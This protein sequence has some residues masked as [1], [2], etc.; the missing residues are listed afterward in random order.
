M[1]SQTADM[2]SSRCI[3]VPPLHLSAC[4][5]PNSAI[6]L[7]HT[8]SEGTGNGPRPQHRRADPLPWVRYLTVRY[9]TQTTYNTTAYIDHIGVNRIHSPP[10]PLLAGYIHLDAYLHLAYAFLYASQSHYLCNQR[11][12]H[13]KHI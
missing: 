6:H 4:C 2:I 10:R 12:V 3:H 5:L 7:T 9:S 13:A 11:P 8:T 1:P